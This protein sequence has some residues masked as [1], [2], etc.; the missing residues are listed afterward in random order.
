MAGCGITR[1]RNDYRSKIEA[2]ADAVAAYQQ[3]QNGCLSVENV[4]KAS[5]KDMKA[6]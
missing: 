1:F 3:R 2:G 5:L 6:R 4:P